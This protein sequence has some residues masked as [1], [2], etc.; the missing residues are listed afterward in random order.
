MTPSYSVG[1]LIEQ[2]ALRY[3]T[4]IAVVCGDRRITYREQ[5]ARIRRTGRALLE[6]GLRPGDRVALLMANTAGLLDVYFGLIWAGFAVVPLDPV[7]GRTDHALRIQDSGARAVVHDPRH[8]GQV[9]AEYTVDS[10]HL[11]RLA[12]EQPA[13][14]GMP[15]TSWADLFGIFYTGDATGQLMGAVHT[16]GTYLSAVMGHLIDGGLGD[17]DR[18]AHVAPITHAGG[19]FVL[20]TWLRGGTNVLM[21]QF[22]PDRFAHT[23]AEE[24]VTATML[25]PTTLHLLMENIGGIEGDLTS[26]R[27]VVYGVA[28]VRHSLMLA[29]LDVLG[30][31]FTHLYGLA[32]AP[33]QVTMLS[34]SDHARA[35]DLAGVSVLGRPVSLAETRLAADG[36]LLVRGPYV[37]LGYWNRPQETGIDPNG[38]L[39]TGDVVTRD[40]DGLL[41]LVSR[42][43]DVIISGGYHVYAGPVET[44]LATHPAVRDVAVIGVPDD[45]WGEAVTAVVVAD[46]AI[47][48]NGAELTAWTA[49]QLGPV[50]AP[51]TV[52]FVTSIPRL[53]SGRPDKAT[54]RTNHLADP[55][56][57]GPR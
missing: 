17:C 10:E 6:L 15:A 18:F 56:V 19:M 55:L 42:K 40:D 11:A 41:R 4:N 16:H 8:D 14:P 48:V 50:R 7:G 32:E 21:R 29:A 44:A 37:A 5:L 39:H 23:V 46:P 28:P 12:D 22:E 3:G 31:V 34:K 24:R 57:G 38:W 51:K 26:L 27:T 20:P 54:L 33:N 30:P 2:C 13:G 43:K 52:E 35:D 25:V 49:K 53:A 45:K 9:H 47:P 36:E 1:A